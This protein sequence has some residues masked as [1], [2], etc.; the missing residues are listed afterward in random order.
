[1]I[2]STCMAEFKIT[3]NFDVFCVD[4]AQNRIIVASK[5][6]ITIFTLSPIIDVQTTIIKSKYIACPF[7]FHCIT[8]D[9]TVTVNGRD[10]FCFTLSGEFR[11]RHSIPG[12]IGISCVTLD[13]LNNVY[14]VCVFRQGCFKFDDSKYRNNHPYYFLFRP[15]GR[16]NID[17][18]PCDHCGLVQNAHVES[19][20]L[21]QILSDGTKSR[22]LCSNCPNTMS[23][24]VNEI[25]GHLVLSDGSKITVYK[26]L[27]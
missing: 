19:Y 18:F 22:I 21:F 13:T 23:I 11:F 12:A 25:S 15:Q 1:M 8:N 27:F 10:V 5:S 6:K 16:L 9:R 14:G 17:E 24:S 3:E 26:L 7:P 4:E 20:S 2:D